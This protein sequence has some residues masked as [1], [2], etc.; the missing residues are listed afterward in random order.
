[1]VI[2]VAMTRETTRYLK[3]FMAETSIAS[4]CSVTRMEPN[5]APM[6]EPTLP[7]QINAVTNGPN[8][9]IMAIPIKEGNHEA[10]PNSNSAGRDCLVKTMPIIKPVSVMS[11]SAFIPIS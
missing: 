2:M 7:A 6:P 10:A 3:G 4:I 11:G 5:S 1:M 9:F 8:A